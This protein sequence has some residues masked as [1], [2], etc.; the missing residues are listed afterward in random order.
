M[1]KTPKPVENPVKNSRLVDNPVDNPT[2][3]DRHH[4]I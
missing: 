2:K 1:W 3:H 4:H